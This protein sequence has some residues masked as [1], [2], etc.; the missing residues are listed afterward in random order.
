MDYAQQSESFLDNN[1]NPPQIKKL[2]NWAKKI[3]PE[4]FMVNNILWR[5]MHRHWKHHSEIFVPETMAP[6]LIQDIQGSII[7]DHE[8]QFKTKERMIKSYC[9]PGMDRH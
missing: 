9:W 8:R 6:K 3:A 2:E 4:C 7:Y 5:R 1:A